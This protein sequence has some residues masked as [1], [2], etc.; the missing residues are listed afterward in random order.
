VGLMN[1]IYDFCK[2]EYG[3]NMQEEWEEMKTE[4][5]KYKPE[6]KVVVNM[7]FFDILS[8]RVQGIL[9]YWLRS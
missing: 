5:E 9:L 3:V 8:K 6:K 7:R 1:L 4:E 2:E